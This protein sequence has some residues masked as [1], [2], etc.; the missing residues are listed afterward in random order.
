MYCIIIRGNVETVARIQ[1]LGASPPGF[2]IVLLLLNCTLLHRNHAK[3]IRCC[4]DEV[5]QVYIEC[6]YKSILKKIAID[7]WCVVGP[8]IMKPPGPP[9]IALHMRKVSRHHRGGTRG[10]ALAFAYCFEQTWNRFDSSAAPA[11]GLFPRWWK[12]IHRRLTRS[13]NRET[14]KYSHVRASL[15][16]AAPCDDIVPPVYYIII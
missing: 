14:A 4:R 8:G 16:T 13:R 11:Q 6:R 10:A 12:R 2:S 5:Q 1:G 7:T 15:Q 3:R 9:Q